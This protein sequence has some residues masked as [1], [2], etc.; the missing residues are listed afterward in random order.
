MIIKLKN[1]DFSANNIGS[2]STWTITKVLGSGATY[3]GPL[4]VDK[5]AAFNATV[6]ISE[7][8][9]LG[10][11]GVVITMGGNEVSNAFV[12]N[13]NTISISIAKVTG[14]V[15]IKV[16]TSLIAG[17]TPQYMFRIVPTPSDATVKINGVEQKSIVVDA[18]TRVTYE[19]SLD[20]YVTR[21][22]NYIVNSDYTMNV[23]LAVAQALALYQ[24]YVAGDE[25]NTENT[26]R[27]RTEPIYGPFTI[28]TNDGYIIRAIYSYP[29]AEIIAG[30]SGSKEV[31][32]SATLTEYTY[33]TEGRYCYITF[34]KTDASANILPSENIIKE[35]S[36]FELRDCVFTINPTPAN[37][38]V[39]LNGVEQNSITV[40]IGTTVTYEVSAD[41]YVTKSGTYNVMDDYALSIVLSE[42]V[43]SDTSITLYQGFSNADQISTLPNRVRTDFIYGPFSIKLNEGYVIRA[44]YE[45][46]AA[47]VKSGTAIVTATQTLTEYTYTTE[48]KYCIITFCKTDANAD[49]LP[50]EN[51]IKEF[52]IPEVHPL[53]AQLDLKMGQYLSTSFKSDNM[54]RAVV[55]LPLND[56]TSIST[57]GSDFVM[58]PLIDDDND[59][60]NGVKYTL[61]TVDGSYALTGSN[62]VYKDTINISDVQALNTDN[63][64]IY[65]MFKKSN[66]SNFTLDSLVDFITIN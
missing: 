39:K 65:V 22:G 25:L 56:Y 45:Y 60:T 27:V 36:E 46:S 49:I 9:K 13:D 3:D 15:N 51:I 17:E 37:A 32:A 40:K 21:T 2:L 28:K 64:P 38:T 5:D 33:M 26:T 18:G 47:E 20:G 12:V 1:A 6:T 54:A 58:I 57:A 42:M 41:G 24:G 62:Y 11:A 31:V 63:K 7:S 10:D 4:Y 43:E 23:E 59:P 35:F 48:G 53:V 44:I 50:T 34:C 61:A 66:N 55:G 16:P 19:V 52:S 29:T 8:Y 14:N 30:G